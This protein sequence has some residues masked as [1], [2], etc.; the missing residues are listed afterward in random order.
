M[1]MYSSDPE[2]LFVADSPKMEFQDSLSSSIWK[3]IP[4]TW[5]PR[6]SAMVKKSLRKYFAGVS[7]NPT[8][9][10]LEKMAVGVG[11]ESA[12]VKQWFKYNRMKDMKLD[13]T[14]IIE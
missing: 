6:L 9:E 2:I 10:A 11:L 14:N 4:K 13:N 12:Q 5:K 8:K 7:K 3:E 1:K